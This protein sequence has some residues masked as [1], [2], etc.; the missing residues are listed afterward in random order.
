MRNCVVFKFEV[1][2]L[3]IIDNMFEHNALYKCEAFFMSSEASMP[4]SYSFVVHVL[5]LSLPT[6]NTSIGPMH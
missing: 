3:L 5:S 4:R 1:S 6:F 2:T